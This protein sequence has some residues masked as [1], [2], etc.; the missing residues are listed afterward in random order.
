MTSDW[1]DD[2]HIVQSGRDGTPHGRTSS[3]AECGDVGGA[4]AVNRPNVASV[5]Q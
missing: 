5:D 4:S 2:A 3:R 1:I